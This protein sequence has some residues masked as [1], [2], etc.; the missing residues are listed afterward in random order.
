MSTWRSRLSILAA[1]ALSVT[2]FGVAT[3]S[4]SHAATCTTYYISTSGSDSNSGCST[5]APWKSLAKVNAT[6]F[7]AG[8][9]ILFQDGGSWTGELEPQGSG[10]GGDHIVISSYGSGAQPIIAGGGAAAAIYLDDQSYW[11]IENLEIT[12]TSSSAAVRSGIQLENDTSGILKGIDILN[13]NINNVLGYWTSTADDQPSTSAGIAFN[14]SDS[15][16]TNGWAQVNIEGNTLTDDDAAG[17]YLG[18]LSGVGHD[19]N[20]TQVLIK[21]NSLTD[22]GGS[23]VV[24]LYCT[25]A[26]VEYN[27]ATDNGSRYSGA[28]FWTAI[29]TGGYWQYNEVSDQHK[30][31]SDGQAFDIDHATTDITVQYNYTHSNAWGFFEFCCNGSDGSVDPVVRYNISQDD[32]SARAVFRLFGVNTSGTAQIYNNT[33]YVDSSTNS[34]ITVDGPATDNLY[35]TNNIIYNTGS[36]GYASTTGEIWTYNT[37]YGNHPSSEPADAHKLTSNPDFENPGGGGSGRSTAS[38]YI[39]ESG[40]PDLG[41]GDPISDNGGL[42]FFGDAVSST[43]APNRGAY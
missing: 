2:G 32:G 11:T 36:G 24:C 42:D 1:A 3:A 30:S 4:V 14:L 41:S 12:N 16:A 33:V 38:A 34:P 18:S 21:N 28:G 10:V 8:D 17:I 5:S 9:S 15:Y 23:D 25:G 19:Q 13:N 39:L 37:F 40:S 7:A 35:L 20:T 31:G 27:V 43:A 26:N 6:T 29:S 22:I